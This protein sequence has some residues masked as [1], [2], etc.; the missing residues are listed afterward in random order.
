[1]PEK[2]FFDLKAEKRNKII[3]AALDE[4]AQYGFNE[5]S[6]NRIVKEAGIG[7]GSLFKYFENKEDLYFYVLDQVIHQLIDE[8]KTELDA[9][10]KDIFDRLIH[11]SATEI[12]WYMNNFDKYR[13]LKTAFKKSDTQIYEKTI[14]KFQ[15]TGDAFYI[16]ILNDVDTKP[17]QFCKSKTVNILKFFLTS[18]NDEF[19]EK[20]NQS[21]DLQTL[22]EAYVAEL[23]DY[24][25]ML[26]QG[27]Y[28]EKE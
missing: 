5:S 15:G 25:K 24:L 18:F 28:K 20:H 22:K 26:K 4:F 16:H 6:T 17:L 10:P 12:T 19:M 23:T 27:L 9:L 8:L 21:D 2:Q 1:M 11:Y 13:L 3:N 14:Q 7:K